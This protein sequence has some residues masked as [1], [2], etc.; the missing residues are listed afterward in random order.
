MRA[1]EIIRVLEADGWS[2]ARSKGSHRQFK[3]PNKPGTLTVPVH[4]AKDLSQN[5]LSAIEKACSPKLKR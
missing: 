1:R 2:E 5:V 4:G 3:H